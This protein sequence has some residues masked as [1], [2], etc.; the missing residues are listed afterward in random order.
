MASLKSKIS[1]LGC[2]WLGL[3]LAEALMARHYTVKGSTT[4][5]DKLNMLSSKGIVPYL[6]KA[7]IEGLEKNKAFFDTD[8]LYINIPPGR[9]RANVNEIYPHEIERIIKAAEDGD[10]K[11]IV[12]I[13]STGVYPNNN[14]VV[15]EQTLT[16]NASSGSSDALLRAESIVK[17][18]SMDWTIIRLAGLAGPNREPGRW[19]AGKKDVPNGLAPVNMIHLTDAIGVS[20]KAIE[21]RQSIGEIFNACSDKHPTKIEFYQAQA[22]KLSL[23]KP[24]FLEELKEYKIISN[25]KIKEELNYQFFY[26]D[27]TQF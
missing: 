17:S 23:E 12:F 5:K 6:L 3:P 2:G 26:S 19:F 7:T 1:I 21:N 14:Q 10:V 22:A 27:P 8:L 25:A 20:I 15:T 16:L 13:S 11:R 4:T 18:C 24:K 9:R